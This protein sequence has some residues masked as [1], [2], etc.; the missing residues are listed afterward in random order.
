MNADEFRAATEA[1]R[2]LEEAQKELRAAFA[3]IR[4]KLLGK[5]KSSKKPGR[6]RQ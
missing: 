5:K 4:T 6:V 2:T 1:L 3:E